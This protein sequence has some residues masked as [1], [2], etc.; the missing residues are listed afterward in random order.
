M[1]YYRDI[2]ELLL[3]RKLVRR[4][5]LIQDGFRIEEVSRRNCN[6]RIEIPNAHGYFVKIATDLER[7]GTLER[8]AQTYRFLH[9]RVRD[10][11]CDWLLPRMHLFDWKASVLVLELLDRENLKALSMRRGL[12]PGR[13]RL[14]GRALG[15]LH[16]QLPTFVGAA[17]DWDA[18]HPLPFHLPL[19]PRGFIESSSP[20]NVQLLRVVQASP[21]LTQELI[22]LAERWKRRAEAEAQLI[23]GDLKLE[24]CCVRTGSK[25]IRIVDWELAGLGD[26]LWDAGAVLADLASTWLM[27]APIPT[28]SEPAE[29]IADARIPIGS[30]RAAGREFWDAYAAVRDLAGDARK[31]ALRDTMSYAAARLLQLAYEHLQGYSDLTGHSVAH[32]QLSENMMR[33]PID[34]AAQI[35]GIPA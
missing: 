30:L 6:L 10:A 5:A 3:G 13:M 26:P 18:F 9:P 35:L 28:G 8:E 33:R 14:L 22:N 19:P 7:K 27:S 24:N 4:S 25:R 2:I 1:D 15:S 32:A 21:I 12:A 34:G 16:Q 23:H 31:A 17:G 20:A 11:G 29:V